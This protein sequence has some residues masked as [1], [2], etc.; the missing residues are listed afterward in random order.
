MELS[1]AKSTTPA[2]IQEIFDR[3]EALEKSRK[4]QEEAARIARQLRLDG[5]SL[6][7]ILDK[8]DESFLQN[9]RYSSTNEDRK[10]IEPVTF[11]DRPFGIALRQYW[12]NF[13]GRRPNDYLEIGLE[14]SY[15]R[16]RVGRDGSYMIVDTMLYSPMDWRFEESEKTATL[17]QVRKYRELLDVVIE[18]SGFTLSEIRE[19]QESA[20]SQISVSV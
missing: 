11:K 20:V 3:E 10:L 15:D 4:E 1:E 17:E 5:I 6:L 13:F 2:L 18:Y 19:S 16:F 14:S 9:Y 8:S 12:H 7:D